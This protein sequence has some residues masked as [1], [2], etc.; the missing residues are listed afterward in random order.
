EPAE[1]AVEPP[2]PPS[3]TSSATSGARSAYH[4]T[5]S[6][7]NS[8]NPTP[9]VW[10]STPYA[11]VGPGASNPAS[12]SAW[13]SA[14]VGAVGTNRLGTNTPNLR[15]YHAISPTPIGF[16]WKCGLAG[17]AT[18]NSMRPPRRTARTNT[19]RPVSAVNPAVSANVT[20][21][22]PA[23]CTSRQN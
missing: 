14:G 17:S 9:T 23:A 16:G 1:P 18:T 10:M 4:S 21:T 12:T 13:I 5:T 19:A 3:T 22:L 11:G 7:R 2:A 8:P 20:R 15:A 6:S